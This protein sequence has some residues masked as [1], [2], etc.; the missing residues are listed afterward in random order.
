M[1]QAFRS[2]AD[3]ASA[4]AYRRHVVGRVVKVWSLKSAARVMRSWQDVV[5]EMVARRRKV[6]RVVKIWSLKSAARVMRSWQD[7]VAEMVARRKKLGRVVKL[8]K[9]R[10]V[11]RA[12][13]SWRG[14]VLRRREKVIAGKAAARALRLCTEGCVRDPSEALKKVTARALE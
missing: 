2:W 6:G 14:S 5:A 8:M 1:S 7:V 4:A 11:A 3:E 9:H 10:Q 12:M 13:T